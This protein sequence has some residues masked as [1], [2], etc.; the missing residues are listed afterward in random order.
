[1]ALNPRMRAALSDRTTP[2]TALLVIAVD[3]LGLEILS[4][5][6]STVRMELEEANG[7]DQ[8]PLINFNKLMAAIELVTTDVFYRSLPDFIRLCNVLYNGTLDLESF[9]PADAAE[10]AWGVTESLLIWPPDTDNESP[11]DDKIVKYIG[12]ALKDEGI[13]VPPDV[14][15]LGVTEGENIWDQVQGT[16]SDDP[17]MFAAIYGVEKAKTDEINQLVKARLRHLLELLD[18]LPLN[19]GDAEDSVKRM[20]A[21]IRATEEQGSK[22]EPAL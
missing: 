18:S 1:M 6:P 7:A 2:S 16:F 10:V 3:L 4:W 15:R 19:A 13:M 20:L 12:Y 11:F 22:L 9:D 8:L 14:L 21:A 5:D 17:P